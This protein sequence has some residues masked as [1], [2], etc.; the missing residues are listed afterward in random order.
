MSPSAN[1]DDDYEA[2]LKKYQEINTILPSLYDAIKHLKAVDTTFEH[3][4]ELQSA[5]KSL[6][7]LLTSKNNL[8]AQVFQSNLITGLQA[9]AQFFN[10]LQTLPE[11][12]T[13][14]H[15][16]LMAIV[17]DLIINQNKILDVTKP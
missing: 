3:N 14:E 12:S 10:N 2:N 16:G 15:T 7:T 11:L 17:N 1:K 8:Q 9:L 6:E 5:E 4:K 13:D